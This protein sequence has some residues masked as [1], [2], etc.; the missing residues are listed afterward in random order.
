VTRVVVAAPSDVARAGLVALLTAIPEIDI[1][2]R[3]SDPESL[4]RVIGNAAP[5]VVL[6]DLEARD[7]GTA[8][9]LRAAAEA[10]AVVLLVDALAD[11]DPLDAFEAPSLRP[12]LTGWAVL[13]RHA[14]SAEIDA[15]VRAVAAGL[16]VTHRDFAERVSRVAGAHA[17]VDQAPLTPREIEVLRMLAAGL[18]N[19]AIAARLGVSSHTVKFHV[20]SIMTKMHASSRTEAVTEGIR[21]GFIFV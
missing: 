9:M 18:P 6:V 3:A 16:I 19:K 10:P 1:A 11:I 17:P 13:P 12:G 7:D 2:G 4:A 20:G 14:G 5:D 21:R 8:A 15:A